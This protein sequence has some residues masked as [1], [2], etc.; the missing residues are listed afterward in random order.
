ER[1]LAGLP[2]GDPATP[3][4]ATNLHLLIGS[5]WMYEGEWAEASVHF[6][7]AQACDPAQPAALR[8]NLDALRGVAALRRGEVENCVAC[9]NEASCIFPLAATAVHRRTAGSGEAIEHFTRYLRQRPEDL[10]IQWLLNVAY[11]TLGEYPEGVPHE[12]LLPLGRF[13]AARD[14]P[15]RMVN[16]ASRV[17]LNARGESMAGGCLVDD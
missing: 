16:V 9:C 3:S 4:A 13:A 7:R 8:A 15:R 14:D 5:L 2:P 11:M 1:K 6:A 17:G 10:G 12:F